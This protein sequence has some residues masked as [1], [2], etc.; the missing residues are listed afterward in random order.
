M[1]PSPHR[2]AGASLL[3]AAAAA[4][5]SVAL[6]GCGDAGGIES[7]G[8]TQPAAGPVR[9]WPDLPPVTSPPYDFGEGETERVPGVSVPDDDVRRIDPVAVVQAE[10]R[11]HPERYSGA[12]GLYEETALQIAECTEKPDSCP[13]LEPAYYRDLTGDG[14][15]ELIV[16]ITMPEQQTVVR[17]YMPQDGALIRIMSTSDQLVSVELAERD[18]ILRSVS[19]GIPGYEYRTH[20]SW[21]DRQQAMLSTRDEIVRVKPSAPTPPDATPSPDDTAGLAGSPTP[22]TAPGTAPGASP[23]GGAAGTP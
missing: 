17:C 19:A 2:T 23:G 21:D 7:A 8:P 15:E 9:L 5:L 14:K 10:V 3:T 22:E 6:S 20:W 18:V 13:V 1:S 4:V 11:S 12:D 16:G